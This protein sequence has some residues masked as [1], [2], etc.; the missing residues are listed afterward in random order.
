MNG[1]LSARDD[2]VVESGQ[3]GG[4]IRLLLAEAN[5]ELREHVARLLRPWWSIETVGDGGAALEGSRRR[6]AALVLGE[7]RG[8]GGRHWCW[9]MPRCRAPTASGCCTRLVMTR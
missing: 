7:R 4:R 1:S 8:R 5:L 9:R 3:V 6:R 2:V